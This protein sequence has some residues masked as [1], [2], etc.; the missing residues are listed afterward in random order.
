M[1][2]RELY[3]ARACRVMGARSGY[4]EIDI[5]ELGI[6]LQKSEVGRNY[7][8]I[9]TPF[10]Q[11]AVTE[12]RAKLFW[13]LQHINMCLAGYQH[14]QPDQPH[15]STLLDPTRKAEVGGTMAKA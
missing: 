9:D 15:V 4:L 10:H 7:Q 1:S 13:E 6:K 8:F 5:S 11:K 14:H 12:L 2:R 3:M